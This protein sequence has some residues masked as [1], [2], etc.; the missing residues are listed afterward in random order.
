M[1]LAKTTEAFYLNQRQAWEV[2]EKIVAQI[3]TDFNTV[4]IGAKDAQL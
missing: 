3:I 2:Q 4:L 1:T